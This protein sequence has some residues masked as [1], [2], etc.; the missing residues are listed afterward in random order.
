[1]VARLGSLVALLAA[2]CTLASTPA[3]DAAP[4]DLQARLARALVAPGIAPGSTS[5]LAVDLATGEIAFDRN[6]TVPLR[7]ASLEKLAISFAAL[8]VLGPG[9]R[10]RTELV[11]SGRRHGGTWRGNLVLVGGGDPSLGLADVDRLARKVATSGITR[12]DGRVLGDETR[13]DTRRD[14]PGWKSSFLGIESRPLSALSVQG[15]RL[16]TADGSAIGAA[17]ALKAALERRGISVA[18]RAGRGAA[19]ADAS[20]LAADVSRP[21]TAIVRHMD[22]ESDNFYAEMLLKELGA[23]ADRA[24]STA[25]GSG[26]VLRVLAAAGVPTDGLRIAD[27]SGLSFDDRL[28]ARALVAILRAGAEDPSIAGA[29]LDSLAVAGVSGT[30]D[31]RLEGPATRGRVIGKTGT[32]NAACALAGFVKR[33]YVFAVVQNG[34]PVPSWTARAAQDRFVTALAGAQESA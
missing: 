30:L 17:R 11:G 10:F 24:G 27:G 13:F 26:A 4:A 5:A 15:T 23:S 20:T 2:V 16:T 22:Q 1:M 19:R 25:S 9:F 14:A 6:S 31:R 18:G 21:L 28:T 33:R 12:V 8:R 34:W 29:F 7:P 3:S 32:T